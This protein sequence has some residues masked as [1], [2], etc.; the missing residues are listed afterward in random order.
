M[1]CNAWGA[2]RS[3]SAEGVARI[4]QAN[5]PERARTALRRRYR[6]GISL[7]RLLG[8]REIGQIRLEIQPATVGLDPSGSTSLHLS[9]T[10]QGS[11]GESRRGKRIKEEAP[12]ASGLSELG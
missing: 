4:V 3:E 10:Y 6:L 8:Q 11:K 7:F 2:P 5:E 1:P 12:E 9:R